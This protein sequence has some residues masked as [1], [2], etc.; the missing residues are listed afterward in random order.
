MARSTARTSRTVP[1]APA[2][3]MAPFLPADLSLTLSFLADQ[4]RERRPHHLAGPPIPASLPVSLRPHGR[5]LRCWLFPGA[6]RPVAHGHGHRR[7]SVSVFR[8]DQ[9]GLD[10]EAAF[11][12]LALLRDGAV[13]DQLFALLERSANLDLDELRRRERCAGNSRDQRNLGDELGPKAATAAQI[14]V[15]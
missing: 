10:L 15:M 6:R 13:G 11:R 3:P 4:Q 8:E 7:G 12:T 9:F 14:H 2:I 5:K 1:R